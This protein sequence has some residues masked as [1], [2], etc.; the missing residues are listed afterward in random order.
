MNMELIKTV[1]AN[2]I[3]T[4]VPDF[5]SGDTVKVHVKIVEGSKQ[6]IQVFQGVVIARKGAGIS[7]SFTVRKMSSQI[8]VERTFSVHSPLVAKIEVI[9]KGAVRRTK[10]YYLRER[11][12]KSARIKERNKGRVQAAIKEESSET[13]SE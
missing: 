5:R 1:T 2:Q 12:G 8:G 11:T 7:E 10:L 4:D 6:R 9:K 3:K 13:V